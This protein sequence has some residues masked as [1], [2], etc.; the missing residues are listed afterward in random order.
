MAFDLINETVA[1]AH[2]KVIGVGGAGGNAV[3]RMAESGQVV[4]CELV[5]VNTDAQD[6]DKCRAS[7]KVLIGFKMTGGLGAGCKPE[8]GQAAAEE[9]REALESV[10]QGANMVFITAGM[11]GG[12]GTGATPI[13][14]KMAKASGILTVAVVTKPFGFE[15]KRKMRL[16]LEGIEKLRQHV[17]SL[18]VIPNEKLRDMME[19]GFT[20]KDAFS[21]ADEILCNGVQSIFQLIKEPGYINTDFADVCTVM[22]DAGLAH[23][24]VGSGKGKEKAKKAIEAAINSPLL[25][26]TIDGATGVIVHFRAGAD[27]DLGELYDAMSF[28]DDKVND[29]AIIIS[30]YCTEEDAKD[31]VTV[32]VIATG[33]DAPDQP[34]PPPTTP[35]P[36]ETTTKPVA[37]AGYTPIY[38]GEKLPATYVP[39]TESALETPIFPDQTQDEFDSTE[40]RYRQILSGFDE[41]PPIS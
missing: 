38:G 17:D 27:F 22:Q 13:I 40:D 16:A 10:L 23:M 8:I 20:V 7:Q 41:V 15:G 3:T 28:I 26:T 6:L 32:T 18:I 34:A 19:T 35:T 11:G 1:T 14:A 2:I 4:G 37:E 24:A 31:E 33:F 25:E 29:D 39:P 30:G 36:Q 5:A 12:T 9:S 21:R